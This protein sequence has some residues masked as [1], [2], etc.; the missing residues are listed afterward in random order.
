MI[1]GVQSNFQQQLSALTRAATL[2]NDAYTYWHQKS[3][4][5]AY[6]TAARIVPS[7]ENVEVTP[8]WREFQIT[9]IGI[10]RRI[11]GYKSVEESISPPFT[12]LHLAVAFDG[13]DKELKYLTERGVGQINKI[14]EELRK[15]YEK[16]A[17]FT[18][19]QEAVQSKPSTSSTSVPTE[20]KER[21]KNHI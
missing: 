15:R 2:L 16:N 10:Q 4:I 5:L 19:Y 11:E 18:P 17:S 8:T 9:V 6:N 13:L 3:I 7:L 20:P 12:P 14:K 1:Y 21:K